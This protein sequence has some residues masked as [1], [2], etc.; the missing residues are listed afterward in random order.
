VRV[1]FGAVQSHLRLPLLSGGFGRAWR[2]HAK[3]VV[4]GATTTLWLVGYFGCEPRVGLVPRPTLGLRDATP[5]AWMEATFVPVVWVWSGT[6]ARIGTG[7]AL[8]WG[9]WSRSR[10]M[11]SWMMRNSP[12]KCGDARPSVMS[13][14]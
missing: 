6:L 3:A 10:T 12:A 9:K 7:A 8:G 13:A 11:D 4:S 2:R 1:P 14:G 5:L